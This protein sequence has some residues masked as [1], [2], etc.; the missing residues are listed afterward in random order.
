MRITI[1]LQQIEPGGCDARFSVQI[2]L[3]NA[4]KVGNADENY[5]ALIFQD[6]MDA[7]QAP[8]TL[9]N[10]QV[11][12]EGMAEYSLK[13]IC[14]QEAQVS[15]IAHQVRGWCGPGIDVEKSR[16]ACV[17]AADMQLVRKYA[18][19]RNCVSALS[20]ISINSRFLIGGYLMP[21]WPLS[22]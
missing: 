16:Q 22:S 4:P 11:L 8:H 2:S 19:R 20:V 18:H 12:K 15:A 13:G 1:D 7:F 14:R 10:K 6:A 9:E 17:T 3:R 21:L 5:N